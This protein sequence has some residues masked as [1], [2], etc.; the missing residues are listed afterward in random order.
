[1]ANP[2]GFALLH[3][4]ASLVGAF[5]V[6]A[7]WQA[8]ALAL[9]PSPVASTSYAVERVIDGDTLR[10]ATGRSV[11][12][13]GI[14]APELGRGGRAGEPYADAA[15]RRLQAL[16]QANG[17][18]VVLVRGAQGRDRHGR[19][20]AYAY[21]RNGDNL[22]AQLLREG[23]GFH[24]VIA[25]NARF[26]QCLAQ[27]EQAARR[28]RLGLWQGSPVARARAVQRS[29]FA[30]VSGRVSQ[31]RR[32]NGALSFQLEDALRIRLPARLLR[33]APRG[34]VDN[35][36]GRTLEVRGWIKRAGRSASG[37]V[38]WQLEITDW[39]MLSSLPEKKC[40]DINRKDCTH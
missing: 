17:G 29:G 22:P 23:L 4:K 34:F 27:A 30:V 20:L 2:S 26:A 28:A 33:T 11:R 24:T 18:R 19:I 40:V 31:V 10:L 1:M 25:P 37:P 8:T 32:S 36:S 5:F 38:R 12:L 35:L 7:V 3:K 9:C 39:R 21:G 6:G 15:R 13:I 16:I 14:N